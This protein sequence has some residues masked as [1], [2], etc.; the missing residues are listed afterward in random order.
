M[1]VKPIMDRLNN[2][3]GGSCQSLLC[4]YDAQL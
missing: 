2:D 1:E 3:F 4:G